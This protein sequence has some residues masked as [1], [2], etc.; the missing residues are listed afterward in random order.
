MDIVPLK[1]FRLEN[2]RMG[3]DYR[4]VFSEK[5]DEIFL[6]DIFK[7]QR[8]R[9]NDRIVEDFIQVKKMVRDNYYKE[10]IVL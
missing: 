6:V 4:V 3:L 2:K 1:E 5:N 7:K 9:E 10:K 8:Q